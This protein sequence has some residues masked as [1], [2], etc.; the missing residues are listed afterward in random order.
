MNYCRKFFSILLLFSVFFSIDAIAQSLKLNDNL[1]VFSVN[2]V[3]VTSALESLS[4]SAGVKFS[5]NP[6]Q[7]PQG[8]LVRINER[9]ISLIKVLD[10]IM[11]EALF[12]YKQTGDHIIIYRNNVPKPEEKTDEQPVNSGNSVIAPDKDT[13][14]IYRNIYDT[15]RIT[16]IIVKTDTVYEKVLTPVSM[17][18]IFHVNLGEE[19]SDDWKFN[20]GFNMGVFFPKV[21][22]SSN[23]SGYM[24]K[25]SEFNTTFKEKPASGLLGLE[26]RA[27]KQRFT[28]SAGINYTSFRQKLVY[29]YLKQTGGFYEKDTLDGYYQIIDDQPVWVWLVDSTY[30][31]VDN[32]LINYNT[33][34]TI[35]YFEFPLSIQYNIPF[36]QSLFFIRGGLITGFFEGASGQY[37]R[38]DEPG[39]MP[40]KE[41]ESKSIVFSYLIA[42]GIAYPLSRKFT[43]NTSLFYR[44]HLNTIFNDYPITT[45]FSAPGINTGL[46]YKLY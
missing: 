19:F 13:V 31:P 28:I 20:V 6:D 4:R 10:K 21:K 45:K 44:G 7:L 1:P 11:G 34:N 23:E 46:V 30:I 39:V 18:D 12:S 29:N 17:A 40:L 3:T 33:I 25:V 5:Y 42:S 27:S 32:Q 38:M 8:K 41:I 43:W 22:Y 36:G 37:P 16:D 2:N 15:V 24:E 14:V 26:V 35:R 9:N